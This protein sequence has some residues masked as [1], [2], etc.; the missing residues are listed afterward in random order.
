IVM[1]SEQMAF[2][3]YNLVNYLDNSPSASPESPE[4]IR[5]IQLKGL[6]PYLVQQTVDAMQGQDPNTR[7]QQQQRAMGGGFG[8]GGVR[9]GGGRARPRVGVAAAG[10]R[11]GGPAP[12]P[13]AP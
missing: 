1:C 12:P 7:I 5:V 9:R 4:T 2:D 11:R 13:A 10:G 6:D 3:I 8:G